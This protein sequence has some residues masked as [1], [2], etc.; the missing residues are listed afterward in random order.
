MKKTGIRISIL[1]LFLVSIIFS[2]SYAEVT[3]KAFTISAMGGGYSF[4]EDRVLLDLGKTFTLGLGYN[5]NQ[6]IAAELLTS[7]IHTDADIRGDSDI[8]C[9]QPRLDILYHIMP[10]N[11]FVPYIAVGIGGFFF[12]SGN[13]PLEDTV[14]AN[15]GLG[16]KLYIAENIAL[17][18]D[19]RYYYSFEDSDNEFALTAGLVI[20]FGGKKKEPEPCGDKDNDGVC[21]DEDQCPDTIEGVRVD[22]VGCQIK[23]DPYAVM[24]KTSD[25]AQ[26]LEESDKEIIEKKPEM[27]NVIVYFDYKDTSIKPQYQGDLE[28]L[29]LLMKE[30]PKISAIIEGHTDSIASDKY[31]LKLSQQRAESVKQFLTDKFGID[32]GRFELKAMGESKPA[33]TNDTDEGRAKN[34]RAITITI[35]E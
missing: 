29:A 3:P 30:F 18:G 1:T 9:V 19:A 10:D 16:A 15:G 20:E 33:A 14:Q 23:S 8:Y 6:N 31:N 28:K 11:D 22:S 13:I 24:Q 4:D 7:Y 12:E 32:A 17:R 27:M 34:R 25:A 21:D 26:A 35:M 2:T 5:F